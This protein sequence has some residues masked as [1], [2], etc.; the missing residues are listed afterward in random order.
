M[1][2]NDNTKDKIVGKMKIRSF[3]RISLRITCYNDHGKLCQ[4]NISFE[5]LQ[6]INISYV[7]VI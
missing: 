2:N 1:S 3:N 4:R 5:L 7:V 6:Y